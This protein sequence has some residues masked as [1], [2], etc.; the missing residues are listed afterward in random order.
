MNQVIFSRVSDCLFPKHQVEVANAVAANG[1]NRE[2]DLS[3]CPTTNRGGGCYC[4]K[5]RY[6]IDGEP[7]IQLYC[8]CKDCL[9]ITGADGYHSSYL[10]KESNFHFIKSTPATHEELSKEGRAIKRH[11]C[12]ECGSN[13][14]AE[15]DLG[16][17]GVWGG[18]FDDSS[19]FRSTKKIFVH[20]AP[21]WARYP[22]TRPIW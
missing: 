7:V 8:F 19:V 18:T 10:V 2:L 1:D 4:G 15:T 12:Q 6:R 22:I 13:L 17:L 11:Y 20:V 3:S 16:L 5:I 21:D 9:S 14:W